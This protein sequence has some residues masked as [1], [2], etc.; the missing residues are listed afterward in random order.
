VVS[1]AVNPTD[2]IPISF[3]VSGDGPPVVLVHGSGLSRA[4]W[5]GFGYVRALREEFT[6]IALDLR[7]HGRSAKPVR[8]EDYRMPLVVEDIL[9]VLDVVGAP[10]AHY[11]G[12]SFGARVGF[13]LIDSHPA[14]ILSLTAAGGTHR[15]PAGSVA[16]TFFT[17]YDYALARGGMAAFLEDWGRAAGHPIDAQTAAAFRANDPMALRAYFRQ[18]EREPGI[19]DARVA[20]LDTSTLLLAGS[21]DRRRYLDSEVAARLMP[22]ARFHGLPGRD[23]GNTLRPSDEVLDVVIPFLRSKA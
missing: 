17:G 11:F 16:E 3:E 19:A 21:L 23:H 5:R 14:R 7:G 18:L 22:H 4:I 1:E 8:S 10:S 12:Y 20:E 2:G 13:A 15:S 6:V 9:A